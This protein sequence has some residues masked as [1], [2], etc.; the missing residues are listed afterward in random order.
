MKCEEGRKEN[1]LAQIIWLNMK[2]E[3]YRKDNVIKIHMVIA[4]EWTRW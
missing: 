1:N 3:Q 4:S 2:E